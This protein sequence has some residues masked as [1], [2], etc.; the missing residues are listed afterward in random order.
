MAL[1]PNIITAN[2][3]GY[4]VPRLRMRTDSK[5]PTMIR[6]CYCIGES[7]AFPMFNTIMIPTLIMLQGFMMHSFVF[8]RLLQLLSGI[9][10]MTVVLFAIHVV[11][12]VPLVAACTIYIYL[13]LSGAGQACMQRPGDLFEC[14][15]SYYVFSSSTSELLQR[16][17]STP[18]THCCHCITI[19]QSRVLVIVLA[20]LYS[21]SV[22][23]V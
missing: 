5:L 13:Q 18:C 11:C 14:I 15:A 1:L 17:Y 19:R 7:V 6:A 4:T 9:Y 20:C 12:C 8:I 3:S 10:M 21:Y 23:E 16:L 2:I 22:H